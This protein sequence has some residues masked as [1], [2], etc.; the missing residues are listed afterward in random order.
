MEFCVALNLVIGN[1]WFTREEEKLVTYES[2][3]IK[4]VIDY[5]LVEKKDWGQ[6]Q[7]VKVISGEVC[8]TQHKLLVLDMTVVP[9]KRTKSVHVPR[10]KTWKLNKQEYADKFKVEVEKRRDDVQGTSGVEDKWNMVMDVWSSAAKEVCGITKGKCVRKETWWWGEEVATVVKDNNDKHKEWHKSKKE[11]DST[12]NVEAKRAEFYAAKKVAKQVIGTVK[13]Q[14][15]QEWADKVN[16]AD[17]KTEIFRIAKQMKK[18]NTELKG[19]KCLKDENGGIV[20]QGDKIKII[21]KDYMNKLF[22]EENMWDGV[23]NCD[24]KEGPEYRITQKEV[25]KALNK[26]KVG[27]ASGPSGIDGDIMKAT[28]VLGVKMR[29]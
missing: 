18:D 22:N 12:E 8:M 25:E 15:A 1:T 20:V 6:V 14:K 23:T 5:V 26:M 21:W 28:G 24:L 3:G 9:K 2:G 16:S 10:I 27:K 7:N 29:Q 13:Q 4:S 17:G 11:A 19:I